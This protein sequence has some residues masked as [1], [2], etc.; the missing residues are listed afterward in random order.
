MRL[1]EWQRGQRAARALEPYRERFEGRTAIVIASGPTAQKTWGERCAGDCPVLAVSDGFKL[2]SEAQIIYAHD[3][4][5][6]ANRPEARKHGALCLSGG[7]VP[8]D[9]VIPL[10]KT[11]NDDGFD[12]RLG[13]MRLGPNSGHLGVHLAFQLGANTAVLV[14]F[15]MRKIN[16]RSHYFGEHKGPLWMLSNYELWVKRFRTFARTM[17]EKHDRTILNATPGSAL[18]FLPEVDLEDVLGPA[19][20]PAA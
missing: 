18:D 9:D 12:E 2:A 14:G 1:H 13:F 20:Q 16:G 19:A 15:D 11:G 3:M 10:Q 6:W 8:F 5:W 7:D 17:A 4:A